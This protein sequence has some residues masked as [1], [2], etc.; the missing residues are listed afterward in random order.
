M[1]RR[2]EYYMGC[3][4]LPSDIIHWSHYR[5]SLNRYIWTSMVL[6]YRERD[7]DYWQYRM[8]DR[9]EHT[10][11]NCWRDAGGRW[12]KRAALVCL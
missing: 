9:A 10:C 12:G 8:R 7:S 11:F 5:W 3:S 2:R 6:H 4:E 1:M